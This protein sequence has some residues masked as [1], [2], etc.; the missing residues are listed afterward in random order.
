MQNQTQENRK[1]LRLT[2][3]AIF[4]TRPIAAE[5][6]DK[7]NVIRKKVKNLESL[8]KEE[9]DLI[10]EIRSRKKKETESPEFFE[11]LIEVSNMSLEEE[12][13]EEIIDAEVIKNHML[14]QLKETSESILDKFVQIMKKPAEK[15]DIVI[16]VIVTV[17]LG[18]IGL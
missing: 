17:A 15:K 4:A 10:L 2:I 14:N 1:K 8:T 3:L 16:G 11:E 7:V 18:A 13:V 6:M 9:M 12:T 5:E